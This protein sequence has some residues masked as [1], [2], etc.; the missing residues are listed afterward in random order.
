MMTAVGPKTAC[1][2]S[3]RSLLSSV[4][5][6]LSQMASFAACVWPLYS[7]SQVDRDTASCR[8]EDQLTTPLPTLKQYPDV[9]RRV[10][11]SPPQSASVYP[12]RGRIGPLYWSLK[13]RVPL[14]YRKILFAAV[15]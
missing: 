2:S 4:K 10:S 8:F 5:S 6:L 13:C 7:A 3:P 11:R 14:R 1:P 15:Q 12:A 9:D